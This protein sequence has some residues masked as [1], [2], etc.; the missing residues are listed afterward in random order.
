MTEPRF[1][2]LEEVFVIHE[3]SLIAYGGLDG[4]RDRN[5]L[6][7]AVMMPQ[8]SFG[9]EYLHTDLFEMAAAYAF[10]IAENQPFL[11]GNKRTALASAMVFLELNG[12]EFG[13]EDDL[14]LYYA[15]IAVANREKDKQDLAQLFRSMVTRK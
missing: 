13:D 12:W 8:S 14:T 11:D 2:T 3:E 6:E 5:L 15:M 9:G 1:L 10:H 7:S 4:V